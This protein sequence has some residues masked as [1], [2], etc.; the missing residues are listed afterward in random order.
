VIGTIYPSARP[1]KD[2][3]KNAVPNPDPNA[4]KDPSS[5]AVYALQILA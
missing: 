5:C 3:Q 4:L 2:V 1:F